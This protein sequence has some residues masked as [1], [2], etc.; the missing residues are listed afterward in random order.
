LDF[1]GCEGGPEN[2]VSFGGEL[3]GYIA[4]EPAPSTCDG[5][6]SA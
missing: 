3:Q 6:G 4:A 5:Y 1:G 2:D